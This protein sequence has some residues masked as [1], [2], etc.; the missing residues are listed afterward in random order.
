MNL[1][2]HNLELYYK[3]IGESTSVVNQKP[4]LLYEDIPKS[5]Y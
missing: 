3:D 2:N 1:F 4:I 5:V